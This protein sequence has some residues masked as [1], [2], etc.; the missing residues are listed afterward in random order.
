MPFLHHSSFIIHHFLLLF[1]VCSSARV[2]AASPSPVELLRGAPHRI[3]V[4]NHPRLYSAPNL[5][6]RAEATEWSAGATVSWTDLKT[7]DLAAI[8]VKVKYK[9]RE[10]WLPDA[11]LAIPAAEGVPG[12]IGDERVDR[13]AGLAP[14]YKPAD[15]VP[16]G[17]GYEPDRQYRL[18]K[19]A[20]V[21]LKEM[22]AAAKTDSVKLLV[23]SGYRAWETQ[24]DLYQRRCDASGLGQ[25]TVAKPGHSEHQLGTAVDL[26]DGDDEKTLEESFG[27]TRAGQWLKANAWRYGFAISFTPQNKARTGIAPEPWH[28]RYWGKANARQRHM[29]ALGAAK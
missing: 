11:C 29:E 12:R 22:F 15:L 21:A 8:W 20:A 13:W 17:P 4:L 19:E 1:L 7:E 16:V 9:G 6:A 3:L 10:G 18:R 14:D 5:K 26:T 27:D 2:A 23:V 24:Q 28:Y 25:Q